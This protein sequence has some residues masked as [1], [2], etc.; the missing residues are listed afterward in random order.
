MPYL[1]LFRNLQ[2]ML[3]Q[4]MLTS[5]S[6]RAEIE[7]MKQSFILKQEKEQAKYQTLQK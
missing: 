3:Q 4:E 5:S 6:L 7:E 2:A 1:F